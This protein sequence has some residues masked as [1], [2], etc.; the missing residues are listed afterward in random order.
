MATGSQWRIYRGA[1][2]TL[3]IAP[4]AMALAWL[5]LWPANSGVPYQILIVGTLGGAIWGGTEVV[6]GLRELRAT[7]GTLPEARIVK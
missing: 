1:L 5:V 2:R 6:G 7:R 4:L 3:V